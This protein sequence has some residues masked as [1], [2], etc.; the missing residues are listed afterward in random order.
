MYPENK[1]L[2]TANSLDLDSNVL[3][4]KLINYLHCA[5]RYIAGNRCNPHTSLVLVLCNISHTSHLG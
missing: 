5:V 4:V 2:S 3:S 1:N